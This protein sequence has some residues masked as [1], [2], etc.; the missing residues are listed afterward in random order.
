LPSSRTFK[1]ME[2]ERFKKL[3]T[4]KM[5]GDL[6]RNT[7]TVPNSNLVSLRFFGYSDS[8]FVQKRILAE[9]NAAA[10]RD[11]RSLIELIWTRAAIALVVLTRKCESL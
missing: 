7:S 4:I 9:G 10:D 5:S 2:V 6:E 11:L 1:T 3:F 8:G